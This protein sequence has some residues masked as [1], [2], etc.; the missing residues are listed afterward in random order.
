MLEQN[1]SA[2]S[3]ASGSQSSDP[4]LDWSQVRETVR[5]LNL[6]VTHINNSMS[7]VDDSV[8]TLLDSF[9]AMVGVIKQI[10]KVLETQADSDAGE[11][12]NFVEDKCHLLHQKVQQ[13]IVAFQFYDR[14]VQK[15]THVSHSLD[16][17]GSLVGN[18]ERLY[19]LQEWA[20]L[21]E[22]IRSRILWDR[23]ERCLMP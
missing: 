22:I 11:F 3:L 15:L 18:K 14:L 12:D 10:E 9:T 6:T 1:V 5:L 20:A 2:T 7:E 21:Q 13:A 8:E 17:L 16:A 4:D 19:N 23:R